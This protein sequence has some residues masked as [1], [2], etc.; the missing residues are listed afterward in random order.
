MPRAP[1]RR[2][3]E[4]GEGPAGGI[5]MQDMNVA[6]LG[7]AGLMILW[8]LS[9][10]AFTN[11]KIKVRG[12][13]PGQKLGVGLFVAACIVI[14][15]VKWGVNVWQLASMAA[16]AAAGLLVFAMK[17]G[18]SDYGVYING[19]STPYKDMKYYDIESREGD[20]TRLRVSALRKE[21]TL[22]FADKDLEP[23]VAYLTKNKVYDME[24]YQVLKRKQKE[25]MENRK[26]K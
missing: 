18:F 6:V 16:V 24:T 7:I 25:E 13:V 3:K 11:R 10:I 4:A 15:L 14:M 8:E 26:K 21:I 20:M 2:A 12:V 5:Y 19:W 17:N 9:A 1:A 23:A 22:L